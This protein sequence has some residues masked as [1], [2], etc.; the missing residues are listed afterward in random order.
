MAKNEKGTHYLLGLI[1]ND[2]KRR[3]DLPTE[4]TIKRELS[5]FFDYI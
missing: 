1:P 4:V 5:V 3:F 2:H